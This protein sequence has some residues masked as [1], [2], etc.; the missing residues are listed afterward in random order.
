M[1]WTDK[2]N[3]YRFK[4][5]SQTG[6][7]GFITNIMNHIGG[8][9]EKQIVDLGA[10]DGVYLSNTRY[11][12]QIGCKRVLIDGDD[13]GSSDVHEHWITKENICQLLN[14]YNVEKEFDLLNIDIDGNDADILESILKEFRPR[15]IVSEFNGALDGC[16]KMKYNPNHE[17]NNDDYY[18][19]SLEYG[20]KI[21]YENGYRIVFQN[22]SLNLY[23]VREDLLDKDLQVD[24]KFKK[25]NYHPHVDG[26]W[27]EANMAWEGSPFNGDF[28]MQAAFLK[29]RDKYAIDTVIETG[30]YKGDTTLWLS[31]N[32]KRVYTIEV[33]KEYYI[34]SSKRLLKT[35]V[36]NLYGDSSELLSI[37]LEN[38]L[39][40]KCIIFLDAHWYAN[41]MKGEF[42]SI[43]ESGIKPILVIHD[44][45][46]PEHPEFQYDSYPDQVYDF[47]SIK[48]SLDSIYDEYDYYYNQEATGGKVGCLFVIPK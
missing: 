39:I 47:E 3:N 16:K 19:Y 23:Y 35:G 6:E 8:W 41:P 37:I 9:K 17:W 29:L 26:E 11:F 13:R 31:D 14:Q 45:K 33:N 42:A 24:L 27:E 15:L 20:N 18:G 46:N 25:A 22:D 2:I 48:E 10:W 28:I 12:E 44:F 1:N 36:R 4:F 34:E 32:F 7:E 5:Y 21:A 38:T 40:N 43:K 30:T